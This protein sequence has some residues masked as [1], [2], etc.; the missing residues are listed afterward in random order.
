MKG[1]DFK[2][3]FNLNNSKLIPYLDGL[4]LMPSDVS[5]NGISPIH[6][7]GVKFLSIIC[8]FPMTS[9]SHI[10]NGVNNSYMVY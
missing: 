6:R 10:L 3:L 4:F 5:I 8:E 9:K 1:H 7:Y 2:M